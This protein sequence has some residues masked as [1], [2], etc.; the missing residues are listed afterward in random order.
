MIVE[1]LPIMLNDLDFILTVPLVSTSME[2]T[3]VL[4]S[5]N[6]SSDFASLFPHQQFGMS[7]PAKDADN[8][9]PETDF[10]AG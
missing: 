7:D 6:R 10:R 8:H 9:R 3:G 4:I 1:L 2:E 5:F